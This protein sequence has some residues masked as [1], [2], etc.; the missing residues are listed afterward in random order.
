MTMMMTMTMIMIMMMII[1][2]IIIMIMI[3]MMMMMIVMMIV[4]IVMMIVMR[5]MMVMMK[6]VCYFYVKKLRCRTFRKSI[7]KL[8]YLQGFWKGHKREKGELL[9]WRPQKSLGFYYFY[10]TI[11]KKIRATRGS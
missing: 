9:K 7:L 6:V 3:V 2:L 5:T 8:Y 11:K 10:K 4:M 1:M